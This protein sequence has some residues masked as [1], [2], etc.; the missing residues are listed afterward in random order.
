MAEDCVR[1][2][3]SQD[4]AEALVFYDLSDRLSV[5][6]YNLSET[7]TDGSCILLRPRGSG[8]ILNRRRKRVICVAWIGIAASLLPYGRTAFMLNRE[9]SL[10]R[11]EQDAIPLKEADAIMG[12]DQYGSELALEAVDLL[13]QHL[14]CNNIL[15]GGKTIV[16]YG[17]FRQTLREWYGQRA[18]KTRCFLMGQITNVDCL[19][20]R[21]I[22]APR[23][24]EADHVNQRSIVWSHLRLKEH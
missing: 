16:L 12:F 15:F 7:P 4:K 8:K 5:L 21:A 19:S 2:G 14:M 1:Q 20:D 13:L 24:L 18:S 23:N 6:R 17:D 3:F 9:C 22:L 10:K 11:E